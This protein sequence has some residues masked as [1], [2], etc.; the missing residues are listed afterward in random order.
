MLSFLSILAVVFLLGFCIFIH[1]LGHLL[2]ALWRGLHV[3]KFSIGFGKKLWGTHY[4]GV[5]YVISMLPFGGYVALPQLDP[6][7]QPVDSKDGTPLPHA[8]PVDRILTA[9]AGPSANIILG[10]VLAAVLWQVGQYKPVAVD[11]YVVHSVEQGSA[12]A[13]AGLKPEDVIRTLNGKPVPAHWNDVL[14]SIVLMTSD[15]TL[16]IERDGAR[17][18]ITYPLEPSPLNPLGEANPEEYP[19]PRFTVKAPVVIERL[20]DDLPAKKAGLK[21]GLLLLSVNGQPVANERD[22]LEKIRAVEG[23]TATIKYQDGDQPPEFIT[24]AP[25]EKIVKGEPLKDKAGNILKLVGIVPG[26]KLELVH[27]NPWARFVEILDQNKRTLTAVVSPQSKVGAKDLSGPLGILN[28]LYRLTRYGDFRQLLWFLILINFGLAILNLMPIPVLDG[29]HILMAGIELVIRRRIPHKIANVVQTVC[30]VLLIGFIIYVSGYD[31]KR[32]VR[33][34]FQK[35]PEPPQQT[36]QTTAD[37]ETSLQP[38]T[39]PK[40]E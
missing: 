12:E 15:V 28:L 3:E 24:L 2:V 23:P 18:E 36:E 31:I 25:R 17:F 37:P 29:G 39:S 7:D 38:T 9:F 32:M 11:H 20:I 8:S 40:D 19:F 5:E 4:K 14:Q 22:F 27:V 21:P 13:A 10:F 16:G 30:A 34:F 35:D 1:E 6:S 33:P 26:P